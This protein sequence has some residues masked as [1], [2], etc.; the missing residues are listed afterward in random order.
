MKL[1]DTTLR[2]GSY[3]IDFQFT[4]EDTSSLVVRL[5]E[6]GFEFIEVG[7]GIGLGAYRNNL[8]H[9]KENVAG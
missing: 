3:V 9:S 7:H 6:T 2:D 8:T 5:E 1:L 4:A